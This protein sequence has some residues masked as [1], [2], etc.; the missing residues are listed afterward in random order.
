M[1]N[2][3]LLWIKNDAFYEELSERGIRTVLKTDQWGY[4]GNTWWN[5]TK[6]WTAFYRRGIGWLGTTIQPFRVMVTCSFVSERCST[7]QFIS[8]MQK[9][10][11]NMEKMWMSRQLSGEA[12]S[13]CAGAE[14]F[15]HWRS[16]EICPRQTW[17]FRNLTQKVKTEENVE[18]EEEMK[19][20]N[21]DNPAVNFEE[22]TIVAQVVMGIYAC[23]TIW[24]TWPK[25]STEHWLN[26][27]NRC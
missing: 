11:F 19:F 7:Q 13:V 5:Y 3:D 21:G 26:G 6:G 2:K 12:L 20:M 10:E 22:G 1:K 9:L 17:W 14:Q 27:N 16:D 25:E 18:V 8:L 15:Q 23:A 4:R 24:I